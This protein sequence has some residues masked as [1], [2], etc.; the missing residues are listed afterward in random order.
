[1]PESLH[2]AMSEAL[3]HSEMTVADELEMQKHLKHLL[4]HLP[5][6]E[7][8]RFDHIFS[9]DFTKRWNRVPRLCFSMHC[10]HYRTALFSL[11]R[12]LKISTMIR[13]MTA[14]TSGRPEWYF[15]GETRIGRRKYKIQLSLGFH[16]P[17]GCRVITTGEHR[18][19]QRHRTY[20]YSCV[21]R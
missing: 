11:M 7:H 9:H 5:A 14:R 13:H 8:V 16:V 1:M 20:S 4:Q 18:S 21:R 15:T 2:E 10:E 19:V 12:G 3:R 17:D 6:M